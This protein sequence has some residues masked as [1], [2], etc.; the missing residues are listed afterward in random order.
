[1]KRSLIAG[2]LALI[3]LP[4]AAALA[5]PPALPPPSSAAQPIEWPADK[6]TAQRQLNGMAC[7]ASGA[8]WK[9]ACRAAAVL[10]DDLEAALKPKPVDQPA[11][12]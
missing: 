1:M 12:K 7:L 5:E 8:N 11:A 6:I 4:I 2:S 10:D 9:Q 3:L